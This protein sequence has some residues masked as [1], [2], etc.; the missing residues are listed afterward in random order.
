MRLNKNKNAKKIQ[1]LN[2]I[3]QSKINLQDQGFNAT[4]IQ[5]EDLHV[6]RRA[7]E[8]YEEIRVRD[9]ADLYTK[10]LKEGTD[11]TSMK[12]KPSHIDGLMFSSKQAEKDAKIESMIDLS[13][14]VAKFDKM[15]KK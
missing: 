7:D 15:K 10:S 13:R 5:T 4:L 6:K 8:E 3:L 2:R 9:L 14:T 1:I 12:L 11:I